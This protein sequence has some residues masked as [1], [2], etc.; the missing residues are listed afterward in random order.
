MTRRLDWT[1][2]PGYPGILGAVHRVR[3][4]DTILEQNEVA[5]NVGEPVYSVQA[6]QR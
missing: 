5:M 6:L 4:Y 1:L 2:L 3:G